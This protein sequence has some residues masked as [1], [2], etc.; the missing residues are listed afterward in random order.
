MKDVGRDNMR[1]TFRVRMKYSNTAVA[2]N[3]RM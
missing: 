3:S 2:T 1:F